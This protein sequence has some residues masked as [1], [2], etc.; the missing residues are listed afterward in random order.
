MTVLG[1]LAIDRAWQD[2]GLGGL[3]LRDAVLRTVQAADIVG[4]RGILVHTLSP[5]AKR[6]YENYGFRKSPANPMTLMLALQ[7][8]RIVLLDG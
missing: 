5:A 2:R 7:D 8:A 6:F 1:R 4:V 3:L